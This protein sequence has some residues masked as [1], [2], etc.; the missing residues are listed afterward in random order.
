[1]KDLRKQKRKRSKEEKKK[2]MDPGIPF[3]PASEEAHGPAG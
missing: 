2:E 3:G 1:M